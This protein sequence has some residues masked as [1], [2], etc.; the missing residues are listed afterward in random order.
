MNYVDIAII[1]VIAISLI[2]SI[3][4]GIVKEVISFATWVLSIF[5]VLN[6]TDQLADSLAGYISNPPMRTLAG[7]VLIILGIFIVGKIINKILEAII[8][9]SWFGPFD[10][11]IG[12]AFGVAR[13]VVLVAMLIVAADMLNINYKDYTAGS[14]LVGHFEDMAADLYRLV[15]DHYDGLKKSYFKMSANDVVAMPGAVDIGYPVGAKS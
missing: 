12:I 11:I 3:K 2:V 13:G 5:C 1:V 8:A 7:V 15:D 10:K 4:R 9:D 14:L 6:Y